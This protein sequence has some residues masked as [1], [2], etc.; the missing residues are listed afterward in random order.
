MYGILYTVDLIRRLRPMTA[1]KTV[2]RIFSAILT[3]F[4]TLSAFLPAFAEEEEENTLA[5]SSKRALLVN[6]DTNMVLY[7]SRADEPFYCGFL[8][9]V[10]TCMIL[11]ESEPDLT[12]TVTITKEIIDETAQLSAA[13]LKA[14]DII[15]LE[16]L[17][18]AALTSASQ[19]A[20]IAIAHYV[21][22]KGTSSFIKTMNSYVRDLGVSATSF[23]G[24]NS[25]F[26]ASSKTTTISDISVIL[27][28]ALT[29]EGFETFISSPVVTVSVNGEKR[30]LYSYNSAIVP[31]SDYYISGITGLGVYAS[32]SGGYSSACVTT[33]KNMRVLAVASDT[34]GIAGI[35]RDLKQMVRFA[36]NEYVSTRLISKG[37]TVCEVGVKTGKNADFVVLT[38]TSDINAL[39]PKSFD[40]SLI[41]KVIDAPEQI[42]APVGR[43]EKLG[44]LILRYN[45]QV[46]GTSDLV[47]KTAV[48][49]DTMEK[50]TQSINAFFKGPFFIAIIAVAAL[51]IAVYTI[52]KVSGNRRRTKNKKSKNRERIKIDM[53]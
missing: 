27:Q 30:T 39:L 25:Y 28:H 36:K 9:N 16:D 31:S 21:N 23:G 6:I 51:A 41:E 29:L 1:R 20:C 10:V 37:D 26:T 53:D 40:R 11:M 18:K 48:E 49:V 32:E 42:E 50:F 8:P 45:G 19:E 43:G 52:A 12:K 17:I 44:T 35:Y 14:G 22:N 34:E 2:L 46:Y 3:V 5:P 4:L 24:V 33:T 47:T 15:S 7:S 13:K 38:V